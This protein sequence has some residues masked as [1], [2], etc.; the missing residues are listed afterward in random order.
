MCSPRHSIF[1]IMPPHILRAIAERGTLEERMAASRT[2]ALDS[3]FRSLRATAPMLRAPTP[4]AAVQAAAKQRT[5]YTA[6]NQQQL[7]GAIVATEKTRRRQRRSGIVE[8][9]NGLG[10]TWDFYFEVFDRQLD[11]RRGHAARRDGALRQSLQQRVLE[12]PAD[13]VR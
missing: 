2:L 12:R 7:P 4:E 3:T 10:A 1:C 9:F 6:N 8:A 11:R 5:I 13:G